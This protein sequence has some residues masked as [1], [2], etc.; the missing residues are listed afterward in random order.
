MIAE[1]NLP[2]SGVKVLDLTTVVFGPYTTQLLG[3]FGADVI[4]IEAPGGDPM[5]RIGPSRNKGMSSIFLGSNRNKRSL[6]LDL[7][8]EK[9]RDVLWRLIAVS[10]MFVHNVRPQKIKT[11]GFDPKTVCERNPGIIYGGLHGYRA[12]GPYG[13]RPAYDDIIQCNSGLAGIFAERDGVPQMVPS[14]VADK[15]AA[16]MAANGLIAAY[17]KRLRTGKGTYVEC[18][19]FEALVSFNLVEHQSGGTF[20]PSV[21][22]MGYDRVLSKYRL[23][24][25]T[26]NGFIAVL[27]YTDKHWVDFWDVV[28]S[29]ENA[30]DERF[31]SMASRSDNIDLLYEKLAELLVVRDTEEWLSLFTKADIPA[32]PVNTLSDL[33][34]DKHLRDIDFFR[35]Y[36]HPSEG[37]LKVPDTAYQ[38]DGQSLPVREHQPILGE[39]SRK[40]LSEIGYSEEEIA[41]IING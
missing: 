32:T 12:S 35:E 3:D 8:T 41:L 9:G 33:T 17:V 25:K 7:K 28:D 31:F 13:G 29:P 4:K 19:M 15:T 2:L 36:D 21:G 30:A 16:L 6:V 22:R 20:S 24:H 14:I 10:D 23:P 18:S 1:E 34:L 39:H 5:R 11:L 40:I 27:P 37:P 38:F 26:K